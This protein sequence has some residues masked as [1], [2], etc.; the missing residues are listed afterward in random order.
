ML[1]TESLNP[2]KGWQPIRVAITGSNVS[3][4]LFESLAA[5]PRDVAIA[6]IVAALE[7]LGGTDG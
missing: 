3:P 6:R 1:A 7:R 5:L 4:P 2:R